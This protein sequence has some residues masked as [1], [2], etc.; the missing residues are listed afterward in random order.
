MSTVHEKDLERLRLAFHEAGHAAWAVLCGERV[1]ECFAEAGHGRVDIDGVDSPYAA[2]IAYAGVWAETRYTR[3]GVRVGGR[4]P[5]RRH[6]T[7]ALS[8]ASP[9]DRAAFRGEP[10]PLWQ[11]DGDLEFIAPR[12]H[13]L[14]FHIFK[15]GSATHADVE[16]I[17]GITPSLTAAAV[18]SL[19]RQRIDPA[20]I[21]P[22]EFVRHGA[23][24]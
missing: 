7:A 22:A 23:A 18:R 3:S 10:R 19:V 13:S 12:I 20:T 4:A 16:R 15:R 2:E 11:I 14:A 1:T 17:L 21:R 8:D 6:V 24:A 5:S 9:E